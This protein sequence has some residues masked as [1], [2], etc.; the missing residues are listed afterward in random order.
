MRLEIYV[1][2]TIC[3]VRKAGNFPNSPLCCYEPDYFEAQSMTFVYDLLTRFV[4]G[5]GVSPI[6][7]KVR[8]DQ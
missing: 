3:E 2:L 8:T 4:W 6:V 7:I 1:A 5:L